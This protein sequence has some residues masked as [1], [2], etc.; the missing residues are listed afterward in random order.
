MYQD[1]SD[2]KF[3]Q[4]IFTSKA[5]LGFEYVEEAKT[6]RSVVI[7]FLC[8]VLAKGSNYRFEDKRFWGVIH[9]VHI[10][11]ILVDLRAFEALLSA[12]KFS[13]KYDID[14]IWDALPE[15]YLRLGNGAIPKLM[16]HIEGYKYDSDLV[17]DE[18]FGLWNLW[19][20]YPEERKGI[21]NFMLKVIRDPEAHPVIR[22]GL[23]ADFAQLGRKNLKPLF[24]GFCER[25]EK[26][27]DILTREDLDY[28][29][30]SVQ[31][32]PTSHYDLES[33][34]RAEETEARQEGSKEKKELGQERVE[35]FILNN[36]GRIL[37][38]DPCPC[39][40]GEKFG[41]CHLRWAERKRTRL[42]EEEFLN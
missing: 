16:R 17:C 1:L 31:G 21:E 23:I 25:E 15:C 19:E 12:S 32:P 4:L 40:S 26:G 34:Y 38:N 27:F 28:F 5:R 3:L 2:K 22:V 18:I 33:L 24:E 11:G 35:A 6:R 9:A 13:H 37:K 42:G 36:V 7:P 14:W 39:G 41:R 30:D 8:D 29:I 10:L 20:A